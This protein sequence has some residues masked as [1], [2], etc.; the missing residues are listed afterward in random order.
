MRW[1]AQANEKIKKNLLTE[2]HSVRALVYTRVYNA[3]KNGNK[4]HLVGIMFSNA[5]LLLRLLLCQFSDTNG[6][7]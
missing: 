3:G 2:M 6:I 1:R 5:R 4:E 7:K